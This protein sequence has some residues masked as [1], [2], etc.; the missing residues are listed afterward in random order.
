MESSGV[1]SGLRIRFCE[2]CTFLPYFAFAFS[3]TLAGSC[4]VAARQGTELR[5]K[6]AT[7]RDSWVSLNE[8]KAIFSA[9]QA[10]SVVMPSISVESQDLHVHFF[11]PMSMPMDKALERAKEAIEGE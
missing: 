10:D 4:K 9:Q 7:K 6:P 2:V 1:E 3:F 11:I 8:F 5:Q